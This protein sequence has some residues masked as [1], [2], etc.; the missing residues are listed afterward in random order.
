MSW[1]SPTEL[2][3][4]WEQWWQSFQLELEAAGRSPET[5]ESYWHAFHQLARYLG[6]ERAPQPLKVTRQQLQGW[7][8]QLNAERAPK[9]ALTR[10]AAMRRFYRWAVEQEELDRSPA[11]G[12]SAPTVPEQPPDVLRLED[13]RRLIAACRGKSFAQRRDEAL[14]RMMLDSGCRVGEL[15]GME[16]ADLDLVEGYARVTG[17]GRRQRLAPLGAKTAAAIDRYLR[18]RSQHRYA[19]S[20]RVWLGERGALGPDALNRILK[21]R[22]AQAGLDRRVWPHLFRHSFSHLF[23]AGGGSEGDLMRLAG[24]TNSAMARRYGASAATERALQSHRERS[25]GDQ[26]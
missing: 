19:R 22:A 10:F 18:A 14:I 15:A 20:A 23:L 2:P 16:L 3:P 11:N 25:P 13:V 26:I 24:W 9:T 1:R 5:L 17:K 4:S 21:R 7:M 6:W 12:L 8:V